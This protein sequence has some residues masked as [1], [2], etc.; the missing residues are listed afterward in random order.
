MS[1]ATMDYDARGFPAW[2][3][4]N[5]DTHAATP[6]G[7]AALSQHDYSSLTANP[8]GEGTYAVKAP[9]GQTIAVPYSNVPVFQ[10]LQGFSL[11]PADAARFQKDAAADPKRPTFW[12]ALT[13][14]VGGGGREQGVGGGMIQVGGQAVKAMAQPLAHPLDTAKAA[15]GMAAAVG[16]G[17]TFAVG[18]QVAAPLAQK[19]L[20][21]KQQGGNALALEN[22]TGQAIGSVEGGRMMGA[23]APKV[24]EAV[25]NAAPQVAGRVA[26]LG[27]T[28]AAAY[29]SALKPSTTLAPAERAAIVQTGLD[30]SIPVSKA[31]LEKA[32]AIKLRRSIRLSRTKSRRILRA[33]SI[34]TPSR[35][36]PIS[37]KP[38]SPTR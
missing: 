37:R 25:A 22:L 9:D 1:A 14:P 18:E 6:G 16:S 33:P 17:N 36:A 20:E 4:I 19:Y 8:K 28:P 26:L 27:K 7:S 5:Y 35:R 11:E 12:N 13:N 34:R 23:A 32:S 15:L 38:S 10:Q 30:N 31:G 21:D 24:I 2:R 3:N 29:E